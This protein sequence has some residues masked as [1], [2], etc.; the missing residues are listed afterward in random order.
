MGEIF[1]THLKAA[2]SS[3]AS[4]MNWLLAFVITMSFPTAVERF[5]H[6]PVLYFFA[7]I[8]ILTVLFVIVLMVETKDKTFIEI[9]REFGDTTTTY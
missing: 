2:A 5:G 6:G 7:L 1:P 8:C 3:S 4:F 9:R